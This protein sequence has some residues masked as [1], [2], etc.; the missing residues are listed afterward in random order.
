MQR[1]A[2]ARSIDQQDGEPP[3]SQRATETEVHLLGDGIAPS[4]EDG[5][6]RRNWKDQN[7]LSGQ[8]RK[9]ITASGAT[10]SVVGSVRMSLIYCSPF[11]DE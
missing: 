7:G 6:R 8:S 3:Q 10:I 9:P 2:L 11:I 5:R 1:F 4:K